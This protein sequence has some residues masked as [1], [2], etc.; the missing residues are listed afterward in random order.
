MSSEE[1]LRAAIAAKGESI[2]AVKEAKA[3]TM[4]D[5]LAPLIYELLALKVSFKEVTGTDFDPPK[6]DKKK[7]GPAQK[8]SAK[9]GPS[10]KELNKL[11][12]KEKKAAAI[13]SQ[14][15]G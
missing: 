10:K 12:A 1:E 9:E 6:D 15:G 13:A 5:D 14:E 4:K 2:R 7:K 8:E 11:A 3:P